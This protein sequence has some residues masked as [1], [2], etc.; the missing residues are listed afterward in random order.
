MSHT[1][2]GYFSSFSL[3]FFHQFSHEIFD[4]IPI[5]SIK[6]FAKPGKDGYSCLSGSAGL[7]LHWSNLTNRSKINFSTQSCLEVVQLSSCYSGKQYGCIPWILLWPHGDGFPMASLVSQGHSL[8]T[9]LTML[10]LTGHTI[11]PHHCLLTPGSQ[12]RLTLVTMVVLEACDEQATGYFKSLF[13]L[14]WF[15]L[16]Q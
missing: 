11:P 12:G 2:F 14:L 7:H 15:K 16:S 5:F 10:S 9:A 13:K 4:I 3:S 8:V 6:S 1:D